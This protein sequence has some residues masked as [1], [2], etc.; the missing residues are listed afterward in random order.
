MIIFSINLLHFL[1]YLYKYST[2]NYK[3]NWLN[4]YSENVSTLRNYNKLNRSSCLF[5]IGVPVKHHLKSASKLFALFDYNVYLNLMLWASSKITLWYFYLNKLLCSL[6]IS[7]YYG[8]NYLFFFY[9][10]YFSSFYFY[11]N[12]YFNYLSYFLFSF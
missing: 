10:S 1:P 5:Y 4:Y 7:N 9:F 3:W 6:A 12:C 8:V 11:F 2:K